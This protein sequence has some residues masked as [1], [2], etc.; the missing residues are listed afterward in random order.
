[1]NASPSSADVLAET[2]ERFQSNLELI[3]NCLPAIYDRLA[4]GKIV[5]SKLVRAGEDDWNVEFRGT[6]FYE[7]GSRATA[8]AQVE[9]FRKATHRIGLSPMGS[10][11]VDQYTNSMI[12]PLVQRCQETGIRFNSAP[13]IAQGWHLIVF[14]WGLGDHILDLLEFTGAHNLIIIEPNIEMILHSLRTFDW[15]RLLENPPNRPLQITWMMD[16]LPPDLVAL[17]VRANL[18]I[19]N[20]ARVDGAYVFQHYPSSF[21]QQTK[22]AIVTEMGQTFKGLGYVQ[23]DIKMVRNSYQNLSSETALM[24]ECTPKHRRWPIFVLGSGPSLDD[25]LD[26]IRAHQD[27]AIIIACGTSLPTL[28]KAGIRPDFFALLENSHLIYDWVA[29]V[30][31]EIDFGDVTLVA[32]DT[33]DGR[34]KTLFKKTVF[35]IRPGLAS[36]PIFG[37]DGLGPHSLSLMHPTVGNTGFAFAT[38]TGFREIYLFGIDL[39]SKQADRHHAAD[40]PYEGSVDIAYTFTMDIT[41]PGNFGGTVVTDHVMDWG[42][43]VFEHAM[44]EEA[45]GRMVYN[46]SDGAFIKGTIPRLPQTVKLPVPPT[47]REAEL[48]AMMGHWKPYGKERFDAAWAEVDLEGNIKSYADEIK[49]LCVLDH[50]SDPLY[51]LHELSKF[52]SPE[53]RDAH[54]NIFRGTL[55]LSL[56]AGAYFVTHAE[57]GRQRDTAEIFIEEFKALIDRMRDFVLDVLRGIRETGHYDLPHC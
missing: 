52:L 10:G 48:E 53:S 43:E 12:V 17:N 28:I 2:E 5:H 32:S 21:L 37:G 40:S 33:V 44:V 15:P 45:R 22:D 31:N 8:R 16:E 25:S 55:L 23:D 24:L 11:A 57:D 3:R 1:M 14:G 29:R 7:T 26:I 4:K 50:P 42:R 41:R 56:I 30:H 54:H 39:G 9:M 19:T 36:T 6:Q 38:A 18:R 27:R 20:L 46:C 35:T 34:L 49:A 13:Q 47:T 51:F